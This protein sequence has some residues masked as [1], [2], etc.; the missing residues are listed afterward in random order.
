M[1]VYSCLWFRVP[2]RLFIYI[3]NLSVHKVITFTT[4]ISWQQM[5]NSQTA[6]QETKRHKEFK[7]QPFLSHIYKQMRIM[8]DCWKNNHPCG[9]ECI[10][11]SSLQDK[12]HN[13]EC[14]NQMQNR[15]RLV[16]SL[17]VVVVVLNKKPSYSTFHQ[18]LVPLLAQPTRRLGNKLD[19]SDLYIL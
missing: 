9:E 17:F 19:I 18:Q 10:L 2:P 4:I 8:V 14:E 13:C 3:F 6:E 16:W 11:S 15:C 12:A 1:F 5:T 7:A